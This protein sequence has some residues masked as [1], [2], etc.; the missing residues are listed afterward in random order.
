MLLREKLLN[1]QVYSDLFRRDSLKQ[2]WLKQEFQQL[3]YLFIVSVHETPDD[4]R[5]SLTAYVTPKR[6]TTVEI[7]KFEIEV[8]SL[9]FEVAESD[10]GASF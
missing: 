6:K 4:F 3:F 10:F 9:V 8:D 2:N 7:L 1:Y 5:L